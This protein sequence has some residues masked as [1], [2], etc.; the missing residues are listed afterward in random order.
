MKLLVM[1]YFPTPKLKSPFS[2]LTVWLLLR[3]A[4]D[5][6]FKNYEEMHEYLVIYESYTYMKLLV[7]CYS[8][9]VPFLF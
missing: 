3:R 6:R 2:F 1:C 7:M 4:Y 5:E 8:A 9:H